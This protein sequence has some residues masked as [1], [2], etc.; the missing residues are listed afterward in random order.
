MRDPHE[1]SDEFVERLE[2]QIGREVRQRNRA[3]TAPAW[4]PRSRAM[5]T[6]AVAGLM[7]VSMGIG[8]AAVAV[9]YEAQGNERRDQLLAAVEQR[10]DLARKRLA[11]V[12]EEQQRTDRQVSV[13]AASP[14]DA[15]EGRIRVAE[16]GAHLKTIELQLEEIRLTGREPRVELSA[17]R[18]SGRDFVGDR[19]RVEMSVPEMAIALERAR[20]RDTETRFNVGMTD[21][22]GVEVAR[23]QVLEV[24][25]AL[26]TFR[27]K[28][29]IR[30]KFLSGG[31]DAVETE[32][33]VLEAEAEQRQKTLAPK[34]ELARREV[35]RVAQ[36]VA[37]GTSASIELAQ[38]RL[39]KLQLETDL[40]KAELDLALVRRQID[41]H[42]VG[43]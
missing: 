31:V 40:S 37:V 12:T 13:G 21:S 15:L 5:A 30:Q 10:A 11:L 20:L 1:P 16:A 8:A 9:A 25:V 22:I 6:V 14:A 7:L 29:D 3:V 24:E 42:R 28:N 26:E 39:H 32:L 17:P 36:R 34:V 23:V 35:D 2:G 19:L 27:R 4:I 43:R 33:R 18:V 41:Q 38:A